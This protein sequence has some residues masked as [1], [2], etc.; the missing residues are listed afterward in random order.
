[1]S[2]REPPPFAI[3]TQPDNNFKSAVAEIECMCVTL[4]A[5]AD[6]GAD[7]A[8]KRIK[9]DLSIAVNAQ[10]HCRT[11]WLMLATPPNLI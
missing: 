2:T 1:V 5:E 8:T 9:S 4:R 11:E 3:S 6:Y 10:R 7:F